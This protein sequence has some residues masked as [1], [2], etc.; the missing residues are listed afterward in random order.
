MKKAV[1]E[2]KSHEMNCDGFLEMVRKYT[3]V[4]A[5]VGGVRHPGAAVLDSCGGEIGHSRRLDWT[6]T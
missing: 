6:L 2:E 3:D 4:T 1:A 5:Y